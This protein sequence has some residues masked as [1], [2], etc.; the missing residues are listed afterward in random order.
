M[1]RNMKTIIHDN[2]TF[3][4][5]LFFL[6]ESS[7]VLTGTQVKQPTQKQSYTPRSIWLTRTTTSVLG[8]PR[9]PAVFATLPRSSTPH[10]R[11]L[12]LKEV[13]LESGKGSLYFPRQ[14]L[15][16]GGE[17]VS[18]F[19]TWCGTPFIPAVGPFLVLSMSFLVLFTTL[20]EKGGG[21]LK[22][23]GLSSNFCWE[24]YNESFS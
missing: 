3:H 19:Q 21:E 20:S 9:E 2:K 15:E 13:L 22:M 10:P 23:S 18:P 6:K 8:G 17:G 16:D 7:L 5:L 24:N 11:P 12:P 14:S 1:W 4:V